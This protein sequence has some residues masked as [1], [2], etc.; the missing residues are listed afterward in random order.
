MQ[1]AVGVGSGDVDFFGRNDQ[2]RPLRNVGQRVDFLAFSHSQGAT[3]E[4]E[5][6]DVGA[7]ACGNRQE[8][9]GLKALAGKAK[10]AG[11]RE[12]AVTAGF[13]SGLWSSPFWSG[14]AAGRY[15]RAR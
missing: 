2:Q 14:R 8:A 6:G 10:P 13:S 5:E 1:P 12:N 7:E 9:L 11:N 4:Q 15:W 3:A